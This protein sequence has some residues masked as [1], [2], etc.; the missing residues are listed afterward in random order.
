MGAA[1]PT[2]RLHTIAGAGI[3]EYGTRDG[4]GVHTVN[5]KGEE[6]EILEE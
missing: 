3:C 5:M 6:E 4:E 2:W 1:T